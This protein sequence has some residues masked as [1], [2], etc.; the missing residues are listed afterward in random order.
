MNDI[1]PMVK[2]VAQWNETL[3]DR[4]C[5]NASL[6]FHRT[7][8]FPWIP[9]VEARWRELRTEVDSLL[10]RVD[11]LPS[12]LDISPRQ[13][14]LAD[15]R[16]KTF[17]FRVYGCEIPEARLLCPQT[18]AVLEGIPDMSTAMFSILQPG[19]HIPA[20]HGPHKGVLRYHLGL[21]VPAGGGCAIRV[22]D[23]TREWVE[24][25]SLVFDDTFE[26]EAW[27]RADSP[28]VVLFVDFLRPMPAPLRAMNLALG[29][30][31]K[32]L[33]PDVRLARD[34]ARRFAQALLTA[35]G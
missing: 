11:Q 9:K 13:Q 22:G 7:E 3:I 29:E 35:Q 5:S 18:A 31:T 33:Q 20:H 24:G 8:Q 17:F 16:W 14:G 6:A 19:K 15:A 10:A 30:L 32:H 21:R 26:H 28:R 2:I 25:E 27:N 12:V 4:H 23:Q 34:T 1:A